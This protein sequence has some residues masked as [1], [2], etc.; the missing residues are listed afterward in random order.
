MRKQPEVSGDGVK[1]DFSKLAEITLRHTNLFL[2]GDTNH[3]D[4]NTKKFIHSRETMAACAKGGATHLMAEWG[5]DE[6]PL[7]EA[8]FKSGK[9]EDVLAAIYKNSEYAWLKTDEE[10]REHLA[11]PAM[12]QAIH[13]MKPL[14]EKLENFKNAHFEGLKIHSIDSQTEKKKTEILSLPDKS[15]EKTKEIVSRLMLDSEVIKNIRKALPEGEKAVAIYGARHGSRMNDGLDDSAD[16]SAIKISVYPNL[17]SYF[18]NLRSYD[19]FN[20]D[21]DQALPGNTLT[22]GEDPPHAIYIMDMRTLYFS[23]KASMDFMQDVQK[24]G[25]PAPSLIDELEE[26]WEFVSKPPSSGPKV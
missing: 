3:D 15:D 17:A 25:M 7:L 18:K 2:I 21:V 9:I 1:I 16:L 10:L 11:T 22:F 13:M 5:A 24:N 8:Y 19:A 20:E 6:Q 26:P 12:Q 23:P 14:F 4:R